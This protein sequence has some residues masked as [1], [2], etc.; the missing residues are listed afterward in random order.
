M[1]IKSIN[2]F[3]HIFNNINDPSRFSKDKILLAIN[4]FKEQNKNKAETLNELKNDYFENYEIKR[5]TQ[6]Y[7]Y[8]LFLNEKYQLWKE[9]EKSKSKDVLYKLL[10]MNFE[11]KSIPEL[12]TYDVPKTKLGTGDKKPLEENQ[13][14]VNQPKNVKKECPPGK[15]LNPVTNRCVQDKSKKT[16]D[17][18]EDKVVEKPEDKPQQ[19]TNEPKKKECPPGKVLNPVTNRCVQD[20]SKETTDKPEDKPEQPTNEPKKKECPPGKVLNPVTNRCVQDKNK[21]P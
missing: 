6:N 4:K 14:I 5:E 8:D 21:K 11:Y 16:T 7:D 12:Y 20:K 17:K 9:Y 10:N 2:I 19:P 15:V 13:K 3:N 18:P 1:E